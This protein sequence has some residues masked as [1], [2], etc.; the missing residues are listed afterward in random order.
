MTDTIASGSTELKRQLTDFVT[1]IKHWIKAAEAHRQM[2]KQLAALEE[3]GMLDDVL[4]DLS[5]S[6]S[7]MDAI[8][9][10]DPQAPLRL[11]A[12]VERLGLADAVHAAGGSME[13][14]LELT[15]L[16]CQNTATCDHWLRG[17]GTEGSEAFC[18]NAEI[19]K[20]LKSPPAL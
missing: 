3:A 17:G 6:R 18:A 11:D 16:H 14:A 2:R 4:H 1:G 15:C 10:A 7:D 12:M 19:F 5:L 20:T 8:V 9:A 13:R